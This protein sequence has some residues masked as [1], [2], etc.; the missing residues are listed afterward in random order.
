MQQEHARKNE[1]TPRLLSTLSCLLQ[2][3]SSTKTGKLAAA[4]VHFTA[5]TYFLQL[6]LQSR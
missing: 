2:V 5:F 4:G 1:E 3:M 6:F